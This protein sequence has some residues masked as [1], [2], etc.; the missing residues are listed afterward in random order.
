[1]KKLALLALLMASPAFAQQQPDAA[2]MVPFIKQQRE[3]AY[4]AI[5]ACSTVVN[6]QQVRIADLEKQLAEA[7]AAK[8]E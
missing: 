4:D 8:K 7:K 3:M 1:M 2:K 5:A 6:E